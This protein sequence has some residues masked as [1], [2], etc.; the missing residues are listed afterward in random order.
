MLQVATKPRVTKYTP[1]QYRAAQAQRDAAIRGFNILQA[2]ISLA[3]QE[4]EERRKELHL[5]P[6]PEWMIE[7]HMGV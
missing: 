3:Q 4:K 6:Y 2:K 7:Y 5:Y 1:I